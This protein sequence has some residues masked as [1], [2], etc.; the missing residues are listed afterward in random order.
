MKIVFI[1]FILFILLLNYIDII[2]SKR[3]LFW[4][5]RFD[6]FFL[7]APLNAILHIG[8][9]F[10]IQ[11]KLDRSPILTP[12][13][14]LFPNIN[15]LRSAFSLIKEEAMT[16]FKL[17]KPI[18][19]DLFFRHLADDG[20][21]RFYIKWY[22]PPDSLAIKEC[23]NTVKLLESMP[24]VHLGMFSILM[25]GSR[26]PPHY[27]P[28]RMCLRYH[29]GISTPNNE[30]CN[31]KIGNNKYFWKDNEDVMFDDTYVHEVINN[32]NSPRIILFLDVERPQ[33]ELTKPI[34]KAMI[35]YGGPI[36]TRANEKQEKVEQFLR[37]P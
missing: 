8:T 13:K 18:K 22:G 23:P 21:K 2:A 35:K 31:I 11:S 7:I 20:W 33:I 26:I 29:L 28:T 1:T 5:L 30:E 3:H 19:N 37:I 16:A 10:S 32:T 34:A 15:K 6:T 27:G 4:Q 12:S 36:T 9:P 17:S 24:E 14:E 25:P